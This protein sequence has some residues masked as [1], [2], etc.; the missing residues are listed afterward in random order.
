MSRPFDLVLFGATGFTGQLVAAYLAEHAPS[1]LKWALAGRNLDKLRAVR[2]ELAATHAGIAELPLEVVDASDAAGLK[3]LAE[4]SR[5][6]CTTVGPYARYGGPLVAACAAAGTHYCDL[7]GEVQFVRRTIDQHHETAAKTGARIVHCCGFD[8]IPSDL[9]CF[10][11]AER[12]VQE[13]ARP[14]EVRFLVG[15][16][17]GGFSGG[18]IASMVQLME[19]MQADRDVRRLA[20][21]P[22]ALDPDPKRKGPDGSD[23]MGVGRDDGLGTWTAPFVMASI[24]TR[25]VRRSLALRGHP[26]GEDFRYSEVMSTGKGP[27]GLIRAT[28]ITV[29]IG[30]FLAA[31]QV[32]PLRKLLT[33]RVLPAPGEGPS[34]AE[35]EAGH[36]TVHLLG[37]G[38]KP[39][40]S[41]MEVRGK[42]VG[43][44]DPGY[45]ET[46]KMLAESALCLALDGDELPAAAGVLTPSTAMGTVLLERLRAAG[47]AFETRV[48]ASK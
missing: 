45:G 3:R 14:E 25:I 32:G 8:S 21:R 33:Q 42:V 7:T 46:S 39:D 4:Q 23:Q 29:G 41:R 31:M 18:T 22:Y 9:G 2:S 11:T 20:A 47:M 28:G 44:K 13:G 43:K 6:V 34:E 40:G 48:E 17:K 38:R 12:L 35:R 1:D 30:G 36:F 15:R 19:E 16:A 26:Y 37:S 10:M 5:A 27:A 24:N